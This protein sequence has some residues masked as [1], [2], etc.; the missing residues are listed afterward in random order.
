MLVAVSLFAETT[1]LLDADLDSLFDDPP[2]EQ[3]LEESSGNSILSSSIRQRGFSLDAAY[4]FY[5]GIA[6]GWTEAPWYWDT[7]DE[8]Y[9][10]II[11]TNMV[12]GLGLDFRISETLRVYNRFSFSFPDF[13]ISVEEFY[14]D[15]NI[16]NVVFMRAGKYDLTWGISPNYPFTNLLSRV[17]AN[18]GGDPYIAKVDI[19]IGIGGIQ[20]L[21]LTRKGFWADPSL[22][23]FREIGYGG[24]YNIA[25][26][27]A[28]IDAGLF[29]LKAMPL[30]GFI[31]VKST[32][33]N[34]ELYA[35]AM[36]SVEHETWEDFKISGNLGFYQDIFGE[37]LRINGELFYNSEYG[38]GWFRLGT[39]LRDEY[40]SPFINGLNIAMNVVYKPGGLWGFRFFTQWLY[41][42]NEAAAQLVPGLTID[43]LPHV[44]ISLAVP[45]ALGSRIDENSTLAYYRNNA[46][47]NNRPFAVVF[48]VTISGDY[49][50][51]HYE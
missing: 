9:S 41:G 5:G 47:R 10:H 33:A 13:G 31:S 4:S 28:D 27:R 2:E 6:P 1:D 11:G 40:I 26:P 22:P 50:Y 35:E 43:P 29:F 49:K 14:F 8:E 39:D 23:A 25:L 38:A 17:P 15:Y 44:N 7:E 45:M 30:R 42:V 21:A 16:N 46:D 24:K 18:K 32:I 19:P 12:A 37:M 48:L 51:G 34:T 36:A 3:T 20:L